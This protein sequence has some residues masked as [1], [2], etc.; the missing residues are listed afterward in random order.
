MVVH[1]P[2]ERPQVAAKYQRCGSR[3]SMSPL[4][5]PIVSWSVLPADP[6]FGVAP[7]AAPAA[8]T[9]NAPPTIAATSRRRLNLLIR[10]SSLERA[11]PCSGCAR[12]SSV[13]SSET[14]ARI[15]QPV[16]QVDDGV[17]D[18]RDDGGERDDAGHERVVE[19]FDRADARVAEAGDVEHR[20]D[21]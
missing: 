13:R 5:I 9:R 6:P 4:A 15:E 11:G 19:V 3:L 2:F 7:M 18:H 17:R 10:S 8:T 20:L 12:V 14:H 16:N 21:E 1:R